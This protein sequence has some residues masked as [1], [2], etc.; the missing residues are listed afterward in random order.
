MTDGVRLFVGVWPPPAVVTALADLP[1]PL[2]PGVRWT[3]P[4]QWHVTLAFLGEVPDG[5]LTSVARALTD[6][7]GRLG[8]RPRAV[9]GPCTA[10]LGQAVL[11][12][13]VSGLDHVASVVRESALGAYRSASDLPFVGHL[14]LARIPRDG[15]APPGL[16]GIPVE[17]AWE[18][19]ELHLVS[20]RLGVG[21]PRYT[22]VVAATVP[23]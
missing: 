1:R 3:S 19:E 13:P 20:S 7:A 16:L 4:G 8:G 22:T 15:G 5:D 12:V 10:V 11:C 23:W 14:T 9:L 2:V 21:G 17:G 6:V 18:V